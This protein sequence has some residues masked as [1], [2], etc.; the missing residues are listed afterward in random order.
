MSLCVIQKYHI[1][2][3]NIINCCDYEYHIPTYSI[4]TMGTIFQHIALLGSC[5]SYFR[6]VLRVP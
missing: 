2:N 3:N 4:V 6:R 1:I 5:S